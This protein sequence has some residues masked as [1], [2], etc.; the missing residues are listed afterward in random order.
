MDANE[1]DRRAALVSHLAFL[2]SSAYA[3]LVNQ[4]EDASA[5]ASMAG[6]GFKDMTRLAGGDPSMYSEIVRWNRDQLLAALDGYQAQLRDLRLRIAEAG[7]T[8]LAQRFQH[9]L[10][11]VR[12]PAS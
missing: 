3:E 6:P 4:S 7:D 1:H 5:V 12:E 2:L 11:S 8:E 10:A 9:A